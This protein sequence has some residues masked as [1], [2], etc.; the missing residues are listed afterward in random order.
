MRTAENTLKQNAPETWL[1]RNKTYVLMGVAV[2]ALLVLSGCAQG[3]EAPVPNGTSTGS[4]DTEATKGAAKAVTGN[5][6][7]VSL[8]QQLAA[9]EAKVASYEQKFAA[10]QKEID[11]LKQQVASIDNQYRLRGGDN[12][13]PRYQTLGIREGEWDLMHPRPH[14]SVMGRPPFMPHEYQWY[15]GEQYRYGYDPRE[16][17]YR[18]QM[19][20]EMWLHNRY[21]PPGYHYSH[22]QRVIMAGHQGGGDVIRVNLG[23]RFGNVGINL[24]GIFRI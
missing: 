23:G 8:K 11:A 12:F 24:G 5:S 18:A 3:D 6:E 4:L 1:G 13:D 19:E 7:V 17:I 2:V 15:G 16:A 10:Q 9:S 22:G 14:Y 20:R 21:A